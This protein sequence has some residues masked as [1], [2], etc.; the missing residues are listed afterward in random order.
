[1]KRIS[2]ENRR[3]PVLNPKLSPK[4]KPVQ[5]DQEKQEKKQE[6]ISRVVQHCQIRSQKQEQ[7]Q[8]PKPSKKMLSPKKSSWR[9]YRSTVW[10]LTYEQ[11]LS[12]LPFYMLRH[13]KGFHLDHIVS[14]SDG[15][16]HS[17]PTEWI[18]DLTNLRMIP[19]NENMLKGRLSDPVALNKMLR[20]LSE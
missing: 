11:P 12:N 6:A 2:Y 8:L 18:A 7:K 10:A 9:K 1:M 16:K 13:F 4:H 3:G 17:I 19:A 15:H 5:I 14:I 20:R